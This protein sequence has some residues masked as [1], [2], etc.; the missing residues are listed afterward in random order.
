MVLLFCLGAKCPPMPLYHSPSSVDRG[1][2][3]VEQN[4]DGRN[5][6]MRISRATDGA[7]VKAERDGS[8]HCPSAGGDPTGEWN[9]QSLLGRIVSQ[10]Y[11]QQ[12]GAAKRQRKEL[13][14][15]GL[16]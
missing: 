12:N 9:M 14:S 13:V 2:G 10:V 16:P 11:L 1:E 15:P 3:K 8:L 4:A 6:I 5:V 7:E